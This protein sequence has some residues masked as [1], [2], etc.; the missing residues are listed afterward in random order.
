MVKIRT[1]YTYQ[2]SPSVT[3]QLTNGSGTTRVL[4]LSVADPTPT[5]YGLREKLPRFGMDDHHA[6]LP[7]LEEGSLWYHERPR[8]GQGTTTY[9]YLLILH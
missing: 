6:L 8:D 1:G 5:T 3:D 7:I 2:L 9:G 4:L